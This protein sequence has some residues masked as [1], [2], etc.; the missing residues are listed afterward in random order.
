MQGT[1]SWRN[2][3]AMTNPHGP[4]FVADLQAQICSVRFTK[5]RQQL[6][7]SVKIIADGPTVPHFPV[8]TSLSDRDGD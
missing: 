1:P 5:S 4:A 6:F 3:R 7:N 8:S 2:R